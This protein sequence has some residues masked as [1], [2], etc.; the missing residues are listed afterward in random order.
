MLAVKIVGAIAQR[1]PKL[2]P[3][4]GP[5][6][7]RVIRGTY[8]AH[9]IAQMERIVQW[10]GGLFKGTPFANFPGID[11]WLEGIAASLKTGNTTNAILNVTE[12]AATKAS[13][14]GYAAVELF[15]DSRALRAGQ[16]LQE[17]P[18]KVGGVLREGIIAAIN[19]ETKDGWIRILP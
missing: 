17:V 9:E 8:Q 19:I 10:R 13:R 15:I 3:A 12:Q 18:R 16:V 6:G 7:V 14:A 1:A 2:L 5:A 4:A 11:G